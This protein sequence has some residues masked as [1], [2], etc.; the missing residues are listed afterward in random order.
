MT[1]ED[2]ED[3]IRMKVFDK[4]NNIVSRRIAGDLFLVPISGDLANMQKIFALSAVA[5]F[6]W[7]KLDGQMN[8]NEIHRDLMDRFDV[9]EEQA[10]ADIK[11]FVTE[12]LK[13]GLAR[14][15]AARQ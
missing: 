4:T 6:I 13:E 5:E 10:G 1:I 9:S 7:D 15:A 2:M 8:L 12:L 3:D 14:E 11:E